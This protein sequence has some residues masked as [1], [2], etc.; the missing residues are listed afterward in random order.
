MSDQSARSRYWPVPLVRAGIAVIA[1]IVITFSSNHSPAFGLAVFGIFAW[2]QGVALVSTSRLGSFS[3]TGAIVTVVQGVVSFAFGTAALL[4]FAQAAPLASLVALVALWAVATAVLEIVVGLRK[5]DRS[6]S[7]RDHVVVGAATGLLA[8]VYLIGREDPILLVGAFGA[9][10]AIIG[11]Y[12]AIAAFSLKW[13]SSQAHEPET[14]VG[15]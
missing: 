2:A 5:T 8:L 13:E 7:S 9:Y 12:L 4:A 1:A 15:N 3:Q 6:P 11:V 10:A 14:A